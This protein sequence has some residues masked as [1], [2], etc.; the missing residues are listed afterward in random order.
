M[1][2]SARAITS[3]RIPIFL[4]MLKACDSPD[5]PCRTRYVGAPLTYC[6]AATPNLESTVARALSWLSSSRI[7]CASAAPCV[8]S[9][10]EAISSRRMRVRSSAFWSMVL[11]VL[12]WEEKEERSSSTV[13]WSPI[14]ASTRPNSAIFDPSSHGT[15]HPCCTNSAHSPTV[16]STIVFPPAL[17][18]EITTAGFSPSMLMSLGTGLMPLSTSTGCRADLRSISP[19]PDTSGRTALSISANFSLAAAMSS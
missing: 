16:L 9:V 10:P 5:T 4:A 18:P 3:S 19:P 15:Q 11:R 7:A 14:D 12:R 13:C 8:G 2:A 17:G 1:R 6:M